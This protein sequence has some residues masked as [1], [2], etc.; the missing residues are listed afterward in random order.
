MA[1]FFFLALKKKV[2]PIVFCFLLIYHKPHCFLTLQVLWCSWSVIGPVHKFFFAGDTGYCDGFKEIGDHHGPF[3]L[4]TIP[5]GAYKPRQVP[6]L[7]CY[8]YFFGN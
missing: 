8:G 4:A 3:H 7:L 1:A 6:L 5:I 2:Y